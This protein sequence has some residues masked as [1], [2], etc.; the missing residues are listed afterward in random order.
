MLSPHVWVATKRKELHDGSKNEGVRDEHVGW[1]SVN[2]YE[3]G[4]IVWLAVLNSDSRSPS[5][6]LGRT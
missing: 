3:H 4:G 5:I 2:P 6:R 1:K